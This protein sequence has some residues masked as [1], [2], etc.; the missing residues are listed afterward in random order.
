MPC[1]DNK[2]QVQLISRMARIVGY[3]YDIHYHMTTKS[4]SKHKEMKTIKFVIVS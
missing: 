4:T 2:E 1:I 3:P